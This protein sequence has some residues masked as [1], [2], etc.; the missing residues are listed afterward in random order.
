MTE[1]C[2]AAAPRIITNVVTTGAGASDVDHTAEI[3]EALK[4]KHLLPRVHLADGGFIDADLLLDSTTHYG[5]ELLGPAR[6]M[7]SRLTS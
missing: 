5:I 4:E 6:A 3:H 1:T 2:D 7:R